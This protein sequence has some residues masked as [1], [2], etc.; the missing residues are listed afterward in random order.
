MTGA[1]RETSNRLLETYVNNRT[2]LRLIEVD[3]LAI[4]RACAQD[5]AHHPCVWLQQQSKIARNLAS[6]LLVFPANG[7]EH[8]TQPIRHHVCGREKIQP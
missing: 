6:Q 4:S 8:F 5:K 7:K 3:Q 1:M 2:E